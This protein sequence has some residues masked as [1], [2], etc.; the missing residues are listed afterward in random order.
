MAAVFPGGAPNTYVPSLEAT[1]KLTVDFSRSPDAFPL[2]KY[3]TIVKVD[4]T[5]GY[6]CEMSIEERGRV[7]NT[8]LKDDVWA[9]G[10]DANQGRGQL[11]GFEFK[12]YETTR[13]NYPFRIGQKAA[14]EASWDVLASHARIYA[15]KAMTK[16]TQ[17]HITLLTTSGN[18]PSANTSAVSSI[19]GVTGK[20]D[21]ST[22]A[23]T[24]I[25]R[26]INYAVEQIMLQTLSAISVEDLM[27]VMSPGCARKISVSQEIADYLKGSPDALNY[28][29][30][31]LGKNAYFGLPDILYGMPVVI[32]DTAKVTSRKGATVARSFL[33]GDATPFIVARPG[34]LEGS[35]TVSSPRYSTCCTLMLEDMTV[36]SKHDTD[37]RVHLGRVVDDFDV[38]LTAP[39]SGFL[40]T[41]A[42]D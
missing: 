22:T 38:R 30:G 5:I 33:L 3:T 39:M 13:Y 16:R 19:S 12:P 1:G 14:S 8:D 9:D 26:S 10:D 27:L 21:A 23:R 29:K 34:A 35:G 37:N 36:E 6:Y 42:V 4:K 20:W 40:F 32:E 7:L 11:E 2:N 41:A 15:Q 17:K 28:V 25:K 24:D 18:W 31:K